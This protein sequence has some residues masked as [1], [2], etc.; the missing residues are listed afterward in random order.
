MMTA[1]DGDLYIVGVGKEK[2]H[3]AEHLSGFVCM[4]IEG[5]GLGSPSTTQP[6]VLYTLNIPSRIIFILLYERCLGYV[7]A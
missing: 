7:A 2:N 6:G 5:V 3:S 4:H 1:E